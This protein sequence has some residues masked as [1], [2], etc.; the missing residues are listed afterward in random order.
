MTFTRKRN[1]LFLLSC[2][3]RIISPNSKFQP[4]FRTFI[5][6]WDNYLMRE[7]RIKRRNSPS[8]LKISLSPFIMFSYLLWTP[9]ALKDLPHTRGQFFRRPC[10]FFFFFF[11][12]IL[13]DWSLLINSSASSNCF[14]YRNFFQDGVTGFV[15]NRWRLLSRNKIKQNKTKQNKTKKT[16][17]T[18]TTTKH[19]K[20]KQNKAKPHKSLCTSDHPITFYSLWH[21]H[22]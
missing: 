7:P 10:F 17:T 8:K 2:L 19:Q 20:Q 22:F 13:N 18:T 16:K 12:W 5:F 9:R 4:F 1:L 3:Y 21:K 6:K 11:F 14:N 15:K